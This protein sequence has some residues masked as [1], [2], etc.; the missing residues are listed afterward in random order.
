VRIFGRQREFQIAGPQ[1]AEN[2]LYRGSPSPGSH[3]ATFPSPFLFPFPP[4]SASPFLTGVRGY[5]PRKM[6][7]IKMLVAEV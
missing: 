4:P 1:N 7:G 3:D 5:H 6:F 2:A